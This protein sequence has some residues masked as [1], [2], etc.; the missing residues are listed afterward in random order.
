MIG[1]RDMALPAAQHALVLDRRA[2]PA[3]SC[4]PASSS[5]AA[6]PPP[7]GRPTRRSRRCPQ[8][9]G[10]ELGPEPLVHQP[11]HPRRLV[12]DGLDQLHHDHHQHAGAG[13]DA[14]PDAAR[15]LVA[16]HH[17][18]PAAAGAAGADLG[19]G[20]AALRP[21]AR[22]QL[23]RP[24]G[25]RRA[26]ALAAP[27]LVLRAPRGLHPD[28]ARDGHRLGD[29]VGV[30]AQADLRLPRDGVLDDRA[31]RSCPGSSTATTCS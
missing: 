1:A 3:S 15:H 13:H 22:H 26:A 28:P 18:H 11:V 21:H 17:R 6:T 10:V 25:R 23:V 31:S 8:Y 16:V 4:C 30:L 5:R 19:G 24:G 27:L 29:P 9:T 7:A 14:V 2:A 12:D 20:D